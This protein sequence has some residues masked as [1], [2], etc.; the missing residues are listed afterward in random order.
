MQSRALPVVVIAAAGRA[1]RFSGEQKILAPVG[2]RPAVCRAA[3][4]CEE[5]C[6]ELPAHIPIRGAAVYGLGRV[7]RGLAMHELCARGDSAAMREFGRLMYI[8]HDG[9]R[10]SRFDRRRP[11]HAFYSSNRDSVADSRL[12]ELLVASLNGAYG[13]ELEA[14]Q[15]RRQ[16]GFY[17]ASIPELDRIVDVASVVPDVL[18]AGL[19]GAGGGGC[20]LILAGRRR[21][22]AARHRGPSAALL[23]A[24]GEGG[25]LGAVGGSGESGGGGGKNHG[26]AEQV[27]GSQRGG[28]G[29]GSA[30]ISQAARS[31]EGA[32]A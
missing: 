18:G 22:A 15:L 7:D 21:G 20:V 10:V 4:V 24:V 26:T 30:R 19:M 2:G 3:D 9:D 28:P 27:G 5:A 17:G 8:T 14:I 32:A 25:G 12:E 13:Q 16:S 29:L 11:Q 31:Q 6:D 23:R 1:K